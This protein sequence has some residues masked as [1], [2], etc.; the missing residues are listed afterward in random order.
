TID[1]DNKGYGMLQKMG[2]A[3]GTGLGAHSSGIVDPVSVEGND[4]R[5]G[6]GAQPENPRSKAARI[7]RERFYQ[8]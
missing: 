4:D 1:T 8:D 5:T 6:L 2:W 3:P 7:T